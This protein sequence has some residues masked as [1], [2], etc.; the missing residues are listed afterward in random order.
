MGIRPKGYK[1]KGNDWPH[2]NPC[3][4]CGKEPE[5]TEIFGMYYCQCRDCEKI[6][7]SI[8]KKLV[9]ENWNNLY[10]RQNTGYKVAAAS[11]TNG[12]CGKAETGKTK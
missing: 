5:Q 11:K 6:E 7:V 3:S 8:T 10:G 4:K 9:T 2:A 1:M 12:G